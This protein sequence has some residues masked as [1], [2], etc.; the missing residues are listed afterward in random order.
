MTHSLCYW[1]E[2]VAT[3]ET[4][5]HTRTSKEYQ[6]QHNG[7]KDTKTHEAGEQKLK[8]AKEKKNTGHR[9]VEMVKVMLEFGFETILQPTHALEISFSNTVLLLN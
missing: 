2:I 9:D 3:F 7:A 1:Y 6:Q 4:H 8:M 5:T